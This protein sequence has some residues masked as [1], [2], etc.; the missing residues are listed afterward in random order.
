MIR[1]LSLGLVLSLGISACSANAPGLESDSM[2]ITGADVAG[3]AEGDSLE[4]NLEGGLAWTLDAREGAIDTSRI[5]VVDGEQRSA[6]SEWVGP[7]VLGRS[8]TIG[9]RP[10]AERAG[11][12]DANAPV[13]Q[14][15]TRG[16]SGGGGS[17][18]YTCN[19]FFCSCSGYDDCIDM[20]NHCPGSGWC[21]DTDPVNPKCI[22]S[23]LAG[24]PTATVSTAGIATSPVRSAAR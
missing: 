15:L 20:W 2:R 23:M 6:L 22:C 7:V 8:L 13:A 16:T 19:P 21:D 11:D 12:E 18:G 17:L 4:L 5:E 10:L 24:R 9:E 14:A 3:L 1:K